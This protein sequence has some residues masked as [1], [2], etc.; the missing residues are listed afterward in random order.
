M[1]TIV[2]YYYGDYLEVCLML[3]VWNEFNQKKGILKKECLSMV[4]ACVSSVCVNLGKENIKGIYFKG[5][6]NKNWESPID[7]VPELSDLDIHI[8]FQDNRFEISLE[9]HF[10]MNE[11]IHKNYIS[12]NPEYYHYPR[13]QIMVLNKLMEMEGYLPSPYNTVRT[14]YGAE[15]PVSDS[16]TYKNIKDIDKNSIF[17]QKDFLQKIGDYLFDKPGQYLWTVIRSLSWRVGP[18]GSRILTLLRTDPFKA[19]S[20]SRSGIVN[21]LH[22][23]KETDTLADLYFDFYINAWTFFAEKNTEAGLDSVK[24]GISAIQKSIEIAENHLV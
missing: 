16:E 17:S 15:Y 2:I 9:Q 20:M 23:K 4:S 7:Y 22:N 21:E 3:S 8:L 12:E 13:P 1:L 10:K 11:D 6:A 5:S 24:A 18:I 19:W 14:V